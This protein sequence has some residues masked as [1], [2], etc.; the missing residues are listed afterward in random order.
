MSSPLHRITGFLHNDAYKMSIKRSE[1]L[2]DKKQK[3][4]ISLKTGKRV[5]IAANLSVN[6]LD[7]SVALI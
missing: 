4:N 7:I 2:K 5:C 6:S 3:L 1:A